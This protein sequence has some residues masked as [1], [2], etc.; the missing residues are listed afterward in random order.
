[1]E[2]LTWMKKEKCTQAALAKGVGV[3]QSAAS[4]LLRGIINPDRKTAE[5]IVKFTGSQV[6]FEEAMYP[7]GRRKEVA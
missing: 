1:M 7:A 2:L 3:S 5:A 6:S 4:Q